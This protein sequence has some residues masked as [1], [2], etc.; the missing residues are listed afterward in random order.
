MT[1]EASIA[2]LEEIVKQLQSGNLPL[3]DSLELF[4]EGTALAAECKK[5][6]ENAKLQ[7]TAASEGNDE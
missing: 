4:K 7:V 6:L 2:R 3:D 1:Y 5:M